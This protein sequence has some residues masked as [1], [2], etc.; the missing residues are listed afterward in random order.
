M[1]LVGHE[2]QHD[3]KHR[4]VRSC[5]IAQ[6]SAI[7][8][9]SSGRG[10][11]LV[12]MPPTDDSE[13]M[14]AAQGGDQKAFGILV[15]RHQPRIYRMAVHMLKNSAEAEDV[16]QDT[17]VRAYRALSRF[18]GRSQPYTWFYRIGV[19]LSLNTIRS[20]KRSK[21]S[22]PIDDP[23]VEGAMIERHPDRSSPDRA[24]ERK[25]LAQAVCRGIDALSETLRT[26]LIMVA[27]DGLSHG[28]AAEI[29]GCPEGTVAWR[30]HEARKKLRALLAD[31]GHNQEEGEA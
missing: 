10:G 31:Q 30:V 23:R 1:S 3:S 17:F 11:F 2:I 7:S 14:V 26:T 24:T 27:V 9:V 22:T 18:D 5:Q 20:R 16:A 15:R 21:N 29:L 13:L 19:N 25:E 12:S 28:E 6:L 8:A 4:T